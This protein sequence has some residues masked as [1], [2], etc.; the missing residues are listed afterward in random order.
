MALKSFQARVVCES[1]AHRC[2]LELTHRLFNEHL[3]PVV[4]ILYG[5]L[6]GRNGPEFQ[7]ILRTIKSAQQAHGQVEAITAQPSGRGAVDTDDWKGLARKL[8]G[9]GT[10]LFDRK[11]ELPGFSSEFRRKVFDTAFQIILSHRAKLAAWREEHKTWLNQKSEWEADNPEY[12]QARPTIESFSALEGKVAKRRGRWHRWLDFLIA[13]PQLAAWRG[14]PMSVTSLTSAEWAEARKKPRKMVA[15]AFEMFFAKNPELAELDRLHGFYQREF[16]R[17]WAKRRHPDGFKH[18]PTLTLP[19]PEKHPAWFSFKK[20]DT[21]QNLNLTTGTVELKVIRSEDPDQRSP[22]GFTRYRFRADRRFARFHLA[23]SE[24]KSGS[25]K[26]D[27]IYNGRL[28][29]RPATVK[30]IKLVFRNGQPYLFFTVYIEDTPSRFPIKQ[31]ALDKYGYRW[32]VKKVNEDE[33]DRPLRTMAIDLGIRHLAVATVMEQG[34]II[35]SQFIHNRPTLQSTGRVLTGIASLEQIAAMKRELRRRLR[36]RGK[37][38]KGQESCRQLGNHIRRM[39]EDRFKK[40]A[41]AVVDFAYARQ[42]DVIVMEELA[43]LI[44]DAERERGINRAL[45][46]WNRGQLCRWIKMLGEEHGI[47]VAEVPPHWTSHVCH[48]CG[49]IGQRYSLEEGTMVPQPVGKLF[50]CP[51]CHYRCNADFNA[52]VNLHR[53]FWGTFPSAKKQKGQKRKLTL[54]SQTVDLD[55]VKKAWETVW[56]T[57]ESPF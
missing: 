43:G 37:P 27:L 35:A 56:P 48:R 30:G 50:G 5:A 38:V 51:S 2:Y 29:P 14:G 41:A 44:P 18:T 7:S 6:R 52:S 39:S 57:L 4:K 10:L 28:G 53:V 49:Q 9:R 33:A 19:S 11:K 3:T 25:E 17:P 34:N 22:R 8:A 26:C 31:A 32:A 21:Y 54:N 36:Q 1:P 16:V 42:V 24:V 45:V 40:S 23:G 20:T 55:E 15:R 47:R 13:N 46:N 12:M